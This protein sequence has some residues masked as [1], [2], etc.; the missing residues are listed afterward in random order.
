MGV[1]ATEGLVGR[2]TSRN[3]PDSQRLGREAGCCWEANG[4]TEPVGEEGGGQ[5]RLEIWSTFRATE[6]AIVVE[7]GQVGFLSPKSPIPITG[8]FGP[9]LPPMI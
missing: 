1:R 7:D 2:E 9:Y 5:G 4:K 3:L 8:H 6:L